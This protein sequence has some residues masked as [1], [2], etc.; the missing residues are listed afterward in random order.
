[1]NFLKRYFL[2]LKLGRASLKYQGVL[3]L[4]LDVNFFIALILVPV[5]KYT[6]TMADS[7]KHVIM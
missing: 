2:Q 6:F 7:A 1:M 5:T 4:S 3:P